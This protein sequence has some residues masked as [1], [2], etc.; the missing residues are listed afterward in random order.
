MTGLGLEGFATAVAKE[1]ERGFSA[2][3]LQA[4]DDGW[5]PAYVW[6]T[7]EWNDHVNLLTL[8]MF[9]GNTLP[10]ST[11]TSARTSSAQHVFAVPAE[12]EAMLAACRTAAAK[13]PEAFR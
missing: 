3:L 10:S 6:A 9:T 12:S 11:G 13:E 4:H 2:V 1:M 7:Y 5:W 8:H